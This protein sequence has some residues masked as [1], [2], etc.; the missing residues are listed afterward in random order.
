VVLSTHSLDV[1][2][3]LTIVRPRGCRVITLRKSDDD[4]VDYR[5]LTI[6]EVEDLMGSGVDVRKIVDELRL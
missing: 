2:Y 5:V 3:A 6:D 4:V 1:L